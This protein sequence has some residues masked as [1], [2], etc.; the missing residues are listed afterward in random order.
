MLCKPRE[1]ADLH[2]IIALSMLKTRMVATVCEASHMC[3][4]VVGLYYSCAS[5]LRQLAFQALE[6]FIAI[7]WRS[8]LKANIEYL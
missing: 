2:V 1:N 6:Y 8:I 3:E 7:M 5:I 4:I